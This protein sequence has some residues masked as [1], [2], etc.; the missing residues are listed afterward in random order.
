MKKTLKQ[1]GFSTHLLDQAIRNRK[2]AGEKRRLELLKDVLSALDRLSH[3]IVFDDAY[4]FGSI[5]KPYHFSSA[6]DLDIG[7]IGLRDEDFFR[8]MAFLSD[9]LDI[10]VEIVQLENHRLAKKIKKEGI[11]WRGTRRE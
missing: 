6:S 4:L 3:K 2:E 1:E 10:D 8:V 5:T 7:F 9:E 11:K